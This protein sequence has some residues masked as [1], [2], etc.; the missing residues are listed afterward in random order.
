MAAAEQEAH[1]VSREIRIDSRLGIHLRPAGAMCNEAVKY[2][3]AISFSK[4]ADKTANAKSVI[5]ILAAGVKFGDTITMTADGDDEQEA[6]DAVVRAL[7]QS[8]VSEMEDCEA[9]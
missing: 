4:G 7:K 2:N 1:M 3:S 9:D 8:F 6:L 5:S